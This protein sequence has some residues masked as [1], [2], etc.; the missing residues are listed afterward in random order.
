[1]N[2]DH[3]QQVK[4]I[5]H[6]ASELPRAERAAF[7]DVACADNTDLRREVESLLAADEPEDEFLAQP[8]LAR[9]QTPDAPTTNL[10]PGQM[11]GHYSIERRLG[12]GGMGV[13]YLAHDTHLGRPAAVKLLRSSFT[14]D[15][16]RVRRFRYEARAASALNHPNILTIYEV[17]QAGAATGG[18]HFIATEFVDGQTLREYCQNGQL[19]LGQALDVLIQTAGALTAAHEAGII[20]RDIKPENIMLRRDGLVKVLDF[21]LAKLMERNGDGETGRRGDGEKGRMG[22]TNSPH[23]PFSTS[24]SRLPPVPASRPLSAP[25]IVMGTVRYMSPEQ[26]RGLEVDHRS[27]LFSLGVVMYELLT[28]RAPFEGETT[29]D[30]LTALLNSQP[31]PLNDYDEHLPA[32]LQVIVHRALAK[33]LAERYQSARELGDDLKRLKE[34]LEF[35]ARLKG[36]RASNDSVLTRKAGTQSEA[37][38]PQDSTLQTRLLAEQ[39][40]API[41]AVRTRRFQRAKTLTLAMTLAAMAIAAA[42]WAWRW[43]A[44]SSAVIDSIAVL[45]FANTGNDPQMEYLPDGLTEALI[46]TLSRLPGLTVRARAVVFTYKGREIDPRQVGQTLKVRAV[47]TGQV[48]REGD[49]LIIRAELVNAEDGTRLWGEQYRPPL[50]DLPTIRDEI[51]RAIGQALLPQLSHDQQQQ[52]ARQHSANSEAFQ[53]YLRGRH[54][55]HLGT[56]Q[57]EEKALSYYQQAVAVDANYALAHAGIAHVYA[58]FSSQYLPPGEA[59]PKAR[60]AAQTALQLDETLPEGHFVMALVKLWGDWDWDSSE[61]EYKRA[62]QLNP[63]LILAHASY[64]NF[65]ANQLRFAEAE[66]EAERVTELDPVSAYPAYVADNLFYFSRQYD[67]AIARLQSVAELNPTNYVP[68]SYRAM[69]FSQKG[70]HQQAISEMRK[71]LALNTSLSLRAWLAYVQARAGERQEAVKTLRE[72]ERLSLTER[73]SPIYIARIYVGLG[74]KDK[75]FEWLWKGYE[76][77]NDHILKLNVD[78]IYDP[79]RDDPRYAELSR[80]IGFKP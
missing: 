33:L 15:T 59:I 43:H 71:A 48:R 18:E 78:P 13:V 72:L 51:A 46:D 23:P 55:Y 68:I 79:L 39:A 52:L 58:T 30:V 49:R 8:L 9:K 24:P 34:E 57:N 12:A 40:T 21:G 38:A 80:A 4:A 7:L 76:E 65:L 66:R 54:F 53:L 1:M 56:R 35:K 70:M 47:L 26:A 3:W 41:R 22:N 63:N 2:P 27:D 77:R 37:A 11:I 73:V 29:A 50:T 17:G 45:P 16:E 62:L 64:S 69:S 67:Q 14:R 20:H 10:S 28:G 6:D 60:R 19:T 31:R 44:A 5:F 25:G 42:V 74:D 61:R 36:R 32:A 75:A